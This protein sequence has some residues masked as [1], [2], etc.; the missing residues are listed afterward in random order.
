MGSPQPQDRYRITDLGTLGGNESG[1]LALNASGQV[2][3]YTLTDDERE[4]GVPFLWDGRTMQ[5]LGTT[6]DT[7]D[8]GFG[9]GRDI[10]NSG[11]VAGYF[12]DEENSEAFAFRSNGTAIQ[13]L[14]TLAGFHVTGRAINASG[15]VVGNSTTADGIRAFVWNGTTM[16]NL[17]TFGGSQSFAND[18]NAA[19]HVTGTASTTGAAHAFLWNG[20]TLRDWAHLEVRIAKA[21]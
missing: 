11:Q 13:N 20:T 5:R 6:A 17:G 3:G 2:T 12:E 21:D 14:G 1:A 9:I 15:H 4:G 19:G 18:I 10:N 8:F 16:K 7:F